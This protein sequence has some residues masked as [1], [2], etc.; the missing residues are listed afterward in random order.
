MT[1][2]QLNLDEAVFIS[3]EGASNSACSLPISEGSS[4]A[5]RRR[6][7]HRHRWRWQRRPPERRVRGRRPRRERRES[8]Q[9]SEDFRNSFPL[10][11]PRQLCSERHVQIIALRDRRGIASFPWRRSMRA[12]FER[13]VWGGVRGRS[14]DIC[15]DLDLGRAQLSHCILVPIHL[16][17][18]NARRTRT[19][20]HGI[21]F[22][23]I[24][25]KTF[26]ADHL[27]APRRVAA[28]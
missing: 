8:S 13:N 11:L 24:G 16:S 12:P 5:R 23:Q 10:Q 14:G 18:N 20:L 1:S 28:A 4:S 27:H 21:R 6:H 7:A 22:D 26:G 25:P 2:C 19:Y 15:F 17:R 9:A 3:I